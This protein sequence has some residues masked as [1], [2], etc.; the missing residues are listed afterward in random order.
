MDEAPHA[1]EQLVAKSSR[2]SHDPETGLST[3]SSSSSESSL[4][5]HDES[6][7]AAMGNE[8]NMA[9]IEPAANPCAQPRTFLLEPLILILLFA[10]NFSSTILKSQIIYQSCTAG[11]GYPEAVCSLLGTKNASNETKRIE[12][13]VQPYAARV[14]LTIKIV[15]CIVPAFC[16]L[17]V[18]ALSDRYGRKPLLLASYLGYALQYILSACIAYLAMQLNGLVSPWFY[19]ITIIPLSLLGSSVT[20]SVAAVCFIGD[21][22]T[23]KMRSYR[24]IAYEL[25]IYVGLLLGSFASGYVY[26]ATNAYIIFVISACAILFALF[27]VAALLPES[28]TQRQLSE[29]FVLL[30]LWRSSARTREHK[31]RSI[32]V[33]LMCVLLLTAFVSDGSNSVFY[34][35]MRAKFHWTVREFTSY[36]SVSILVPAV[37]GSGGILFLWSLRQCSKSA[38]L[39]LALISLLSHAASSLMKAFAFVDWQIYLAIGLGIFKSL[40]NPMCRTMITNLLPGEERGKVFAMLSVLQTL[41]PF[42][43]STL[44][45]IFYT[46]TLSSAPGLFNLISANLF[47]LAIILLLVVWRKKATHPAHY[48]PIFK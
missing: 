14:F 45:I 40:V 36:E 16:G 39:W 46:L 21:V 35:F 10:Y 48:E 26:E 13:E 24:M 34:M 28:L 22:S 31:D 19:V 25:C 9:P 38:I 7:V 18:G 11:F 42:A 23:G 2:H 30:D 41:S 33:L 44:Y 17:F 6:I 4:D 5:S 20:Y 29:G 27:L 1:H 37:A 8:Q 43:S 15:E 47:G 32:L 3:P 12:A